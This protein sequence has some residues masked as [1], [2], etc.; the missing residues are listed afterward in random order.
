MEMINL[1]LLSLLSGLTLVALFLVIGVFFPKRFD[2]TRR[3]VQGSPGRSFW[4][5]LV[6]FLFFGALAVA[7]FALGDN[8]GVNLLGLPGLLI[9]V[10]LA[11]GITFG[12]SAAALI[13]GEQVFPHRDPLQRK[14]YGGG[15]LVLACLTPFLGW[16]G[17]FPYAGLL[18][19]GAFI[20]GWFRQRAEAQPETSPENP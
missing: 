6:N 12:L 11:V 20:E 9:L 15:L 14:L 2:F 19:L 5:G 4:L 3:A 10:V 17:L 13:V 18:G 7:F 1:L 8:F 16:F